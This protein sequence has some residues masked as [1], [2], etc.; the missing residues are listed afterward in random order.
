MA[1]KSSIDVDGRDDATRARLAVA[2]SR[3]RTTAKASNSANERR[4]CLSINIIHA[5]GG[6][7]IN[8]LRKDEVNERR[9][10]RVASSR[11]FRHN[12]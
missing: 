2:C 9:V 12:E 7:R 4:E 10:F 6:L 1:S 5:S 11:L 3:M 8:T